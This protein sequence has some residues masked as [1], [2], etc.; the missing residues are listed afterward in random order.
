MTEISFYARG[1]SSTANNA[2]LNAQSTSTT[3]TTLLTFTN[4][5]DP[6]KDV[7]LD[8]N[9]GLPDPDTA[10]LMNGQTYTFTLQI[11]GTPPNSSKLANVNGVDLRGD[12][13]AV[14]TLSNGQRFFFMYTQSLDKA[15]MDAFPNGAHTLTAIRTSGAPALICFVQGTLIATPDGPRPVETLN[16]GD[17]VL[18]AEG[19]ILPVLWRGT[20][21]VGMFEA[22]RQPSSRPVVIPPGALGPACP[23]R[24]LRLSPSH[25]IVLGGGAAELLF[26]EA[27]VLVPAEHLIGHAGIH[28]GPA[29]ADLD[30]HHILL[31]DHEMVLA[32][33]VESESFQPAA[34]TLFA[35]DAEALAALMAALPH[36]ALDRPDRY[37]SLKRHES[38]VLLQSM[39]L[40][41]GQ[42]A[43]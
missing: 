22:M 11:V 38:L 19:R 41:Q 28:R 9:N 25:R 32:E 27:K 43:A 18:T 29:E 33:G 12:P 6:N 26:G 39:T 34:R 23:D 3:P 35:Q 4:L 16:P 15:T 14:I 40:A 31:E 37:R 24:T 30:F 7:V 17:L 1:D 8:F 20:R 21:R 36:G 2:S 13:V 10:V 42:R 5:N